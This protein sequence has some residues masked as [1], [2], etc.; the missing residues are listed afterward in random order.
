MTLS[1]YILL[2]VIDIAVIAG[3]SVLIGATAPRW[4][5]RWLAQDTWLTRPRRWESPRFFRIVRASKLAKA[6]PE[7]GSMFGGE[8]KRAIPGRDV[9]SWQRYAVEVRRA[10]WVHAFS[11]LTWLPL[12]FFNP[13]GMTLAGAVIAVVINIPFLIVLRGNNARLARRLRTSGR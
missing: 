6:L 13:W 8:S 7:F 10:I 2:G 11:V 9:A 12:V 3:L 4:P 5:A 1:D